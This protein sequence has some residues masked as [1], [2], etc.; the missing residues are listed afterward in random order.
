ML[1]LSI[2][3]WLLPIFGSTWSRSE[4][5]NLVLVSACSA[6]TTRLQPD[7]VLESGLA[8]EEIAWVRSLAFRVAPLTANIS[9]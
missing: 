4:G 8:W 2:E 7:L 1:L 3:K 5:P 6:P 9:L